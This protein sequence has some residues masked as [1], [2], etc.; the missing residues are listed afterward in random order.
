MTVAAFAVDRTS[1]RTPGPVGSP[2]P[3]RCRGS[4]RVAH[5]HLGKIDRRLRAKLRVAVGALAPDR[6]ER[7]AAAP[8]RRRR[9]GS[10]RAGRGRGGRRGRC[11]AGRRRR[12]ARGCSRRRTAASPTRSRRSRRCRR[13]SASAAR[14]RRGSSPPPARAAARAEIRAI[15]SAAGT[16][17][18]SRQPFVVPTSMYSMKRR[19]WPLSRKWRAISTIPSSLRPRL[20]TVF[21][22]TGRPAS[23]AAS[24]PSRTWTPKS[25]RRS[26]RERWRRRA[27]RG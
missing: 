14:P 10:S 23:V 19:E 24:M 13:C 3:V 8:R 16:T 15:S 17:S 2:S 5:L 25:R 1:D 6:G 21:T 11:R 20:T 18:S 26:S 27:S 4:R 9:R 7:L 12:S 22:F